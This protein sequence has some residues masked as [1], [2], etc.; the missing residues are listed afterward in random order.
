MQCRGSVPLF[1]YQEA[2]PLSPKPDIL[3]QRFDPLYK[4]TSRHFRNLIDEYGGPL[5]VLSLLKQSEKRQREMI[6]S[7]ELR[8]GNL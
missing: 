1:W 3:L 4:A 5:V 2:S 8:T 7:N 6:L